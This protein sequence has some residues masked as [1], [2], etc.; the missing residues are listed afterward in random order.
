MN[1]FLTSMEEHA[2]SD[3]AHVMKTFG[4]EDHGEDGDDDDNAPSPEQVRSAN[5]LRQMAELMERQSGHSENDHS[6]YRAVEK[7]LHLF[8]EHSSK[9]E[10]NRW[11]KKAD[12]LRAHWESN[13]NPNANANANANANSVKKTNGRGN[14]RGNH[15]GNTRY[16]CSSAGGGGGGA[17]PKP[18]PYANGNSKLVEQL[19]FVLILRLVR[20]W[21]KTVIKSVKAI[22]KAFDKSKPESK[23]GSKAKAARNKL[24]YC[25]VFVA[26]NEFSKEFETF[27]SACHSGARE[28][29]PPDIKPAYR[30]LTRELKAL[31][32][33]LATHVLHNFDSLRWKLLDVPHFDTEL[34]KWIEEREKEI[35]G[36]ES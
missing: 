15:R 14:R 33:N 32:R 9:F 30:K 25:G 24:T 1:K 29:T 26:M 11:L 10:V 22:K 6:V 3:R 35:V 5:R 20:R 16:G 2:E 17:K 12:P 8:L 7:R 13:P 27:L 23:T 36:V 21:L 28:A 34:K 19:Y 4:I 31:R 18:K